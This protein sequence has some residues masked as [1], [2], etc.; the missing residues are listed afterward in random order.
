MS[1]V[2]IEIEASDL[3]ALDTLLRV[4]R[5]GS[6][7]EDDVVRILTACRLL[8]LSTQWPDY[9]ILPMRDAEK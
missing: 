9:C 2:L 6:Q 8:G 3:V 1:R 5:S 4:P 7:L